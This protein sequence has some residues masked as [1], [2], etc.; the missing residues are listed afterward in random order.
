MPN[1]SRKAPDK[2]HIQSVRFDKSD[3][4]LEE[5][6]KYCKDHGWFVD[7][8]DESSPNQIRFR[9]YQPDDKKFTY[10]FFNKGLKKGVS[11]I[12]GYLK[13]K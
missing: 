11:F 7:G 3:W 6:K 2:T 10:R 4:T 8:V 12:M 9:Q 1:V 5:A 13:G